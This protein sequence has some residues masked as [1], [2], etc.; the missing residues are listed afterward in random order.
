MIYILFG[1]ACRQVYLPKVDREEL[2]RTYRLRSLQSRKRC[3]YPHDSLR[4]K[5]WGLI[6][7]REDVDQISGFVRGVGSCFRV[8]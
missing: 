6:K 8:C 5:L 4:S 1:F 3:V 7:G 2:I